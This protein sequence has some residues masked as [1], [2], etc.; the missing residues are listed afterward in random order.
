V[1]VFQAEDKGV[2][3]TV[4][5]YL[6]EETHIPPPRLLSF[7]SSSITVIAS[8]NTVASIESSLQ[9]DLSCEIFFSFSSVFTYIFSVSVAFQFLQIFPFQFQFILFFSFVS[10]F[11]SVKAKH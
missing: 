4:A 9:C 3:L 11:V 10:V 6:D 2:A 7:L 1:Y 8:F 5:A